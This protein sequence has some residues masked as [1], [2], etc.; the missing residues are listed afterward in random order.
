[1]RKN[2]SRVL[3]FVLHPYKECLE[4]N[5]FLVYLWCEVL[6]I[7]LKYRCENFI[8]RHK[9]PCL[10]KLL[11][12]MNGVFRSFFRLG[13]ISGIFDYNYI[14]NVCTTIAEHVKDYWVILLYL[15]AKYLVVNPWNLQRADEKLS[16]KYQRYCGG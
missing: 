11:L 15:R 9:S 4:E 1:M 5:Y 16:L 10:T 6:D 12:F 14:Y 3:C 8:I 7:N 2:R 13:W